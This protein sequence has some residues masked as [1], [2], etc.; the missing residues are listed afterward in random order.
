MQIGLYFIIEFLI[1][2][3]IN[4]LV[5]FNWQKCQRG[6]YGWMPQWANYKDQRA[7]GLQCSNPSSN[8]IF[9]C[10]VDWVGASCFWATHRGTNTERQM[11]SCSHLGTMLAWCCAA[12]PSLT[13]VK[14]SSHCSLSLNFH[15]RPLWVGGLAGTGSLQTDNCPRKGGEFKKGR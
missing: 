9:P 3:I 2:S 14:P 7:R 13:S 8:P 11:C 15:L 10:G 5:F 12:R 1:T 4:V 6:E